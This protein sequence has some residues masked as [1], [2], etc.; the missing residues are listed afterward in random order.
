MVTLVHLGS[1]FG[2]TKGF[3]EFHPERCPVLEN[4]ELHGKGGYTSPQ[5]LECC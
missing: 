4:D 3:A 2:N 5:G 1:V